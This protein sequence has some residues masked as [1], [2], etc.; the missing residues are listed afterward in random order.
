MDA[1]EARLDVTPRRLE[2]YIERALAGRERLH[3]SELGFDGVDDFIVLERI[4]EVG[5]GPLA[6]RYD[7]AH[8]EGRLKNEWIDR[9]AFTISR[10]ENG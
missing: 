4:H 7:F 6:A 5:T 1:F 3:S 10:R 2:A 8:A 9:T